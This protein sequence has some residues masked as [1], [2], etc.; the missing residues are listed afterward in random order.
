MNLFLMFTGIVFWFAIVIAIGTWLTCIS[1]DAITHRMN[2][3]K[4]GISKEVYSELGSEISKNAYWVSGKTFENIHPYVLLTYIGE[5]IKN[6]GYF[7]WTMSKRQNI[8][9]KSEEYKKSYEKN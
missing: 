7:V 1:I 2:N 5:E 4:A 6:C 9:N 3:T 8:V